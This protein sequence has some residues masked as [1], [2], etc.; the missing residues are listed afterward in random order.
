MLHGL[1]SFLKHLFSDF[2]ISRTELSE[3]EF[4]EWRK[5]FFEVLQ[6]CMEISRITSVLIS[7]NGLMEDEELQVDCRGHPINLDSQVEHEDFENFVLVGVWLAVKENG[8]ALFN[9][10]QWL[11]LPENEEDNSKFIIHENI[12]NLANNYLDMLF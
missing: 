5:F 7:N 4:T 10:L 9:I 8:L 2:K 1:L 11:E 6:T 3:Q 12:V